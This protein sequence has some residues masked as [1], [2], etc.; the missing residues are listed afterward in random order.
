MSQM[1]NVMYHATKKREAQQLIAK[2]DGG[3]PIPFYKDERGREY[4]TL[5]QLM[6][7]PHLKKFVERFPG[8]FDQSNMLQD[9][10]FRVNPAANGGRSN[11]DA[12]AG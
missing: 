5:H 4:L 11:A 6:E 8:M 7:F 2:D 9:R 3:Q 10:H 1:W 12:H